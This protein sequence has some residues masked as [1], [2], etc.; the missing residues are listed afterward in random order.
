[1]YSKLEI[2]EASSVNFEFEGIVETLSTD[3]DLGEVMED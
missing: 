1:M 3:S 2:L